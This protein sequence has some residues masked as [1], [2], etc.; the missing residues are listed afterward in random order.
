MAEEMMGA[1]APPKAN[2]EGGP[3]EAGAQ[4]LA[5]RGTRLAAVLLDGVLMIPA[6]IVGGIGAAVGRGSDGKPGAVFGIAMAL[7]GLWIIAVAVYQIYL[8]STKGQTV[9]KRWMKIRIVKLDGS[10]P[11]FVHAV[12]LRIF[13]NALI[14]FVPYLG[15]IYSLVD[16]LFIFREDRRCIHDLIASTRVV[17]A[18]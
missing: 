9:G 12:L 1:F 11:G 16:T 2:L 4:R 18:E 7:V 15:A 13:V 5:E 17:V 14:G 6:A 10:A 8:L 3:V